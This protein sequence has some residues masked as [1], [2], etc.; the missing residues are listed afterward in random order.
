MGLS[1]NGS[2]T[3]LD[4]DPTTL[5][6]KLA[7]HANVAGGGSFDL[8]GR[9]GG[10]G[11][12]YS[13]RTDFTIS[14]EGICTVDPMSGSLV[15]LGDVRAQGRCVANSLVD[16]QYFLFFTLNQLPTPIVEAQY[17]IRTDGDHLDPE[18]SGSASYERGSIPITDLTPAACPVRTNND[19]KW[20]FT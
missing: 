10:D 11:G 14:A 20:N 19:G 5:V 9:F 1:V 6:V 15:G 8:K 17:S 3:S 13:A 2:D 12:N 16:D 18:R 7:V 4:P